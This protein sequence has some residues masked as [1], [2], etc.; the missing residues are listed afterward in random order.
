MD[1]EHQGAAGVADVG[2]VTLAASELPDQPSVNG[3]K[4]QL[5]GL[6]L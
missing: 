4:R 1:V 6:R 5:T 3:A 2:D